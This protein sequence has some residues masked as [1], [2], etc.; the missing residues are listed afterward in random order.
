[1]SHH[2]ADVRRRHQVDVT[3]GT[4]FVA[5]CRCGWIGLR[6]ET[7]RDA[8]EDGDEHVREMAGES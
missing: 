6:L 2:L 8:E 1:M 4:R 7:R 5:V 3:A